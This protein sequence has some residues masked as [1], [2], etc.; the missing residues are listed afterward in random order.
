MCASPPISTSAAPPSSIMS[1]PPHFAASARALLGPGAELQ[2]TST[3]TKSAG[4]NQEVDWH[5][6]AVYEKVDSIRRLIFWNALV[7]THPENGGLSVLPGSHRKGLVPHHPSPR[8]EYN[9][10]AVA[11][12]SDSLPIALAAGDMLV[13]HPHLIHGSPE[14]RTSGERVALM[15]G[16]HSRGAD[17]IPE[18]A[19]ANPP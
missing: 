5:Q 6:D 11:D 19:R 3:I 8:N 18:N 1:V 2:F 10:I 16:Y 15:A 4:K 14:N 13:I 12:V 7:D 17:S 9:R